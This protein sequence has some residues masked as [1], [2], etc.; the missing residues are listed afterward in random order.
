MFADVPLTKANHL[1]KLGVSVVGDDHYMRA[2][3]ARGMVHGEPIL[4]PVYYSREKM[5]LLNK[6]TCMF[7]KKYSK[8]V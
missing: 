8:G 3:L 5:L 4:L 1:A 6:T 2:L 7:R